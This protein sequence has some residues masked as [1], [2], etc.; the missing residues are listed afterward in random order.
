[1]KIGAAV[2]LIIAFYTTGFA[3]TDPKLVERMNIMMKATE[4]PDYNTILDYTYPKI[5]SIVPREKMLEVL[6]MT[7]ENKQFT[8]SLDSVI[9][10]TIYPVFTIGD[11]SYAKIIHSQV[12]RM[13]F[14]EQL[15]STNKTK[16]SATTNALKEQ[17]G[18]D[19]VRFDT[20]S[21]T[22]NIRMR[23]DMIA[24]KDSFASEWSFINLKEDSPV[25]PMIFS[26]E[27]LEK[28]KQYK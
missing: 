11:A 14:K 18:E 25:T 22:I 21:N 19:K 5:F 13:K 16:F 17:F 10:D 4:V 12:M 9:A 1:M 23:P 3:Q 2:A 24:I 20:A 26:E 15:D 28:L 6:Q 27:V 8:V 7:F